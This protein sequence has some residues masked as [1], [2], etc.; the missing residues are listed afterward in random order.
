MTSAAPWG[1][2]PQAEGVAEL[3]ENAVEKVEDELPT[4]LQEKIPG[5]TPEKKDSSLV[6]TDTSSDLEK[7]ASSKD[8]A[9]VANLAKQLTQHSIRTTGGNDYPNPFL[10]TDDPALDPLSGHFKPAAWTKTLLGIE[11]RD[12]ERYPKRTAGVSYK[13]LSVHGFGSLTDYQKYNSTFQVSLD[14]R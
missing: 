7:H 4:N 5:H 11:S 8:V 9:E 2:I 6:D 12:P 13:N 1:A 14:T 3:V 10:G